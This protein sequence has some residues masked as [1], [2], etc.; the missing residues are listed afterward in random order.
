MV[1]YLEVLGS[2]IRHSLGPRARQG[3][4]NYLFA[5]Y[6]KFRGSTS[7]P[8][9]FPAGSLKGAFAYEFWYILPWASVARVRV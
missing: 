8:L 6:Q 9:S 7:G 1:A 5:V 4:L 3:S 2:G